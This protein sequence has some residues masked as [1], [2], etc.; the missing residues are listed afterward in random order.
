M[1]KKILFK[2]YIVITMSRFANVPR[3]KTK[4]EIPHPPM[5]E[6]AILKSH[7]VKETSDLQKAQ[8]KQAFE[9][10]TILEVKVQ[11]LN[12]LFQARLSDDIDLRS[13]LA[14]MENIVKRFI[15]SQDARVEKE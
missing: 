15:S 9:R 10:I 12:A 13:N 5:K 11:H 7:L 2:A 3:T 8:L 6:L 14:H 4:R 1:N